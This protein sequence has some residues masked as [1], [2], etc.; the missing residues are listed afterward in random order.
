MKSLNPEFIKIQLIRG[1]MV[2]GKDL[3]A[4][5]ELTADTHSGR[6]QEKW[7]LLV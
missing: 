7:H 2:R 1:L 4:G 6:D 3:A 5:L